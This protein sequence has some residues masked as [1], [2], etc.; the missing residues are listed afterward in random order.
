MD[1]FLYDNGLCHQRVKSSIGITL[2]DIHLNWLNWFHH[3]ILKVS[4]LIILIDCMIFLSPFLNVTSMSSMS[5]VSF[6]AQLDS[7]ILCI[8]NAFL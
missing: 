8:Q 1:W 7:V 3:L 2:V 4:L 5:A 6:L